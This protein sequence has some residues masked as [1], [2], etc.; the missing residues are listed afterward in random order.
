[1][2]PFGWA[3]NDP[4][5]LGYEKAHWI[6]SFMLSPTWKQSPTRLLTQ[7]LNT[8]EELL[9]GATKLRDATHCSNVELNVE[10]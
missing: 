2:G 5:T 6:V 7:F 4:I 8:E 9:N 10:L 1:M 3:Q